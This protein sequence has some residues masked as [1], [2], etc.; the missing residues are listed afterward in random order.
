MVLQE[1][2]T[3]C[4]VHDEK[5]CALLH[6][7]V[8]HAHNMGMLQAGKCLRLGKEW[9]YLLVLER[10]VQDFERCTTFEIDMLAE[11]DF[12]EASSPK[13]AQQ[14]IVAKLLTGA[15]WHG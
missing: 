6:G 4:I 5:R 10:G 3:R 7:K 9:S 13:Q 2:S 11:V 14:S 15:I 1:G 8:E 12:C